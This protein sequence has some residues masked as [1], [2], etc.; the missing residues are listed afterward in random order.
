MKLSMSKLRAVLILLVVGLTA[1]A[2]GNDDDPSTSSTPAPVEA[3][4]A[5]K[6]AGTTEGGQAEADDDGFPLTFTNCGKEFT[7]DSAP[8]RVLLMEAAAPSLLFA[9]GAMDRVIA[10]IEDFPEEYYTADEMAVLDAIPALQAEATSTGGVE[11]SL[12]VIIDYE[13]DIVIGFDNATITHDALA[14]VGIQLYVMPPFCDNPPAPSFESILDEVRF[15][16]ELFGTTDVADASAAGLEAA[17]AS[18]ADAPVAAGKTSAALYVSSD[19]SAIYAYSS[20]GMVHPLMEALGMTNVF[21][22]LSE[23]V[24]E[25]SI[26]EVIGR[27]PEILVLL[28]DDTGLTPEEISALVTDL[29]GASSITAVAEGAVYPLLFNFAEPPTPLVVM[30]LSVLSAEIAH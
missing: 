28:Y 24:P 16:G 3:V 14:D 4:G 5:E 9:A 26:E 11:V 17:V 20:L 6:A 10:R 27:N 21:A 25:V 23:R 22:E 12:E 15:Y 19:G 8:E 1:S 29:P 18:A 7:L 30:G 2:C 13:P